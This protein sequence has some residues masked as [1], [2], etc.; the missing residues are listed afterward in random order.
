MAIIYAF[1]IIGAL[2]SAVILGGLGWLMTQAAS[3]E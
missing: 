1:A 2:T 3:D